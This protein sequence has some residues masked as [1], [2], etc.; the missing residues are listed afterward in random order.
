[1]LILCLGLGGCATISETP[2]PVMPLTEEQKAT[3]EEFDVVYK[4]TNGM[5]P[6]EVKEIIGEPDYRD[7]EFDIYIKNQNDVWTYEH[8]VIGCARFVVFF[9]DD[10]VELSTMAVKDISGISH[11]LTKDEFGE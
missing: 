3:M 7:K 6:K 5:S 8:P 4:I 9:R 10:R 1:M 11:Y 2:E